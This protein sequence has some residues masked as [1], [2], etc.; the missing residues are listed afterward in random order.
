M[1]VFLLVS[2]DFVTFAAKFVKADVLV[3]QRCGRGRPRFQ[4][5]SE[6]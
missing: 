3:R 2:E 4:T 1:D 5:D 6:V